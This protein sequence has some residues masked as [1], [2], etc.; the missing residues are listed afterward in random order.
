MSLIFNLFPYFGL[1]GCR[2]A[3]QPDRRVEKQLLSIVQGAVRSILAKDFLNE[4][5]GERSKY[6]QQFTDEVKEELKSWGLRPS[7]TLN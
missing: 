2:L 4:I 7:R 5:M 1:R 6:G 3:H